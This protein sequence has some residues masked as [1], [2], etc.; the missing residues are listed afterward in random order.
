MHAIKTQVDALVMVDI[1]I[2]NEEI[3]FYILNSLDS[4]YKEISTA[5]LACDNFI[6]FEKLHDNF[7]IM[8]LMLSESHYIVILLLSPSIL[9]IK[10][11]LDIKARSTIDKTIAETIIL[12]TTYNNIIIK[13]LTNL[14]NN[15]TTK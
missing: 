15:L 5:I 6:I 3:I 2:D 7:L 9:L 10:L 14:V 4:D 11:I 8:K 12:E 1:P 13:K